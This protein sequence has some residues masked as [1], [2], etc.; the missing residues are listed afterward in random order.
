MRSSRNEDSDAEEDPV[1]ASTGG[2]STIHCEVVGRGPELRHWGQIDTIMRDLER[3][4]L[5][6]LLCT[7]GR[8]R[9]KVIMRF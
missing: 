9:A 6:A 7:F 3:T 1:V 4:C 2:S 5:M 8:K